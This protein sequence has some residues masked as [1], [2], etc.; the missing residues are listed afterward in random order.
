[1]APGKFITVITN[2]RLFRFS[3]YLHIPL[4][5]STSQLSELGPVPIAWQGMFR[6]AK[7]PMNCDRS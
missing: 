1:M 7:R 3:P 2:A 4:P 5:C 6:I